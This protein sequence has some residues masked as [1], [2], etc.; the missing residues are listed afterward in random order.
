MAAST[1]VIAI[2][3]VC[4]FDLLGPRDGYPD[5]KGF[6]VCRRGFLC[7]KEDAAGFARGP[8]YL[9]DLGADEKETLVEEARDLWNRISHKGGL[10]EIMRCCIWS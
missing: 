2:E 4:V 10:S 1:Q 6:A 5:S 7:R 3:A 8:T 9:A